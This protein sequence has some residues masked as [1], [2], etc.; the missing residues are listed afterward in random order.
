MT[1]NAQKIAMAIINDKKAFNNIKKSIA[2]RVG[3]VVLDE[4]INLRDTIRAI[5]I[6]ELPNALDVFLAM[7][8]DE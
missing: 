1:D 4:Q 8:E 3:D 5:I 2:W 7:S 6:E